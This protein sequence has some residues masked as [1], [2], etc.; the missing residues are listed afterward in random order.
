M[1]HGNR[2]TDHDITSR[3]DRPDRV[4]VTKD[5]DFLHSHLVSSRPTRLLLISTGNVSNDELRALFEN[6]INRALNEFEDASR[7]E[8]TATRLFVRQ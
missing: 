7:I 6:Q 4:V 8:L 5:H 2:T 3:A 1:P